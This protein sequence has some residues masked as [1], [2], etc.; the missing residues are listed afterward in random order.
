MTQRDK[1]REDMKDEAEKAK[2]GRTAKKMTK[3]IFTVKHHT[4]QARRKETERGAENKRARAGWSLGNMEKWVFLILLVMN[5][6]SG[7]PL[8]KRENIV[9]ADP[10]KTVDCKESMVRERNSQEHDTRT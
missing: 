3:E 4:N 9:D 10:W 7:D 1:K 8:N 5:A 2:G 6:G